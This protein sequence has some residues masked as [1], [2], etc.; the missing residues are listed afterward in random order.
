MTKKQIIKL[1]KD[2]EFGLLEELPDGFV[3]IAEKIY[4]LT[5]ILHKWNF[6]PQKVYDLAGGNL[7]LV[8][9]RSPEMPPIFI[10]H[11]QALLEVG[12]KPSLLN[13]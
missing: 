13:N 2:D 11:K 10:G 1:L 6:I 9:I 5:N 4:E 8:R 12:I 7:I 3:I